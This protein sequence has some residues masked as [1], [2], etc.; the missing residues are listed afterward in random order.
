[1]RTGHKF[2][3]GIIIVAITLIIA[4][5]VPVGASLGLFPI[6]A[7]SAVEIAKRGRSDD[8]PW[9]PGDES[10][11]PD[12]VRLV[13]TSGMHGH[14]DRVLLAKRGDSPWD[15]GEE[16]GHKEVRHVKFI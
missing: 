10:T 1:M 13:V 12:A 4:I 14:E 11:R 8:P 6:S 3:L 7:A 16:S 5:A 9:D 2:I 15:P